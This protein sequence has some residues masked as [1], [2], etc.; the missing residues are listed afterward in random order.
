MSPKP[1]ALPPTVAIAKMDLRYAVTELLTELRDWV[2]ALERDV[3]V[4]ESRGN[5]L[6]A[7][8][9][10]G[11]AAS[12]QRVAVAAVEVQRVTQRPEDRAVHATT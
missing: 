3:R 8:Q 4:C 9:L 11:L 7:A 5:R 10:R 2:P 12:V 6:L 1:R